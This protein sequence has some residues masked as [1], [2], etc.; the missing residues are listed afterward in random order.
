MLLCAVATLLSACVQPPPK[1]AAEAPPPATTD[2]ARALEPAP[3]PPPVTPAT[4][5]QAQ[6]TALAAVDL[7]EAGNEDQAKVELQRALT[8]DP[9]NRLALSLTRQI[10]ADP[11]AMLGKESFAYTV[12]PS[13]TLSRIAGRFLGDIYSFYILARY[14]GIKVP[15]QVAGGQVIRV[16]GK[17]PPP[18]AL[19]ADPVR[20]PT[21]RPLATPTPAPTAIPAS[22][23]LAPAPP[24]E[25]SASEKALMSAEAAERA[26]QVDKAYADY[27]RAAGAVDLPVTGAARVEDL[28]RKLVNRYTVSARTAFSK[29]DLDGSIRSWERVMQLDPTNDVARLEQQK[30]RALKEKVK[31]LK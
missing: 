26:G 6:K 11:Q 30:A 4:Q 7:L 2:A 21:G 8:G 3:A 22:T 13:D 14:N 23:P 27:Q 31:S 20:P 19:D 28:R 1:R 29:Q 9:N 10:G 25:I 12:R 16:P 15:R 17:A 5:Q 18:G 24:P